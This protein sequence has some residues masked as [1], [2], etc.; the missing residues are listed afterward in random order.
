MDADWV[1][2]VVVTVG[3]VLAALLVFVVLGHLRRLG[4]ERAAVTADVTRRLAR[5][6]LLR[7]TRGKR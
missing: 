4:R 2:W 3:V 7:A 5:L 1:V 6:Q